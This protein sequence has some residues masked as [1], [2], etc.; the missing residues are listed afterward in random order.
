METLAADQRVLKSRYPSRR[1]LD[2]ISLLLMR[3][4]SNGNSVIRPEDT[5]E[6]LAS[7]FVLIDPSSSSMGALGTYC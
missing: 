2:A 6:D 3:L 7:S 5:S 4:V 1:N